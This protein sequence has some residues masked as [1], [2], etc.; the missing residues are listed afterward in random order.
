M[1]TS[2]CLNVMSKINSPLSQLFYPEFSSFL[3]LQ[4]GLLSSPH[5]SFLLPRPPNF[6]KKAFDVNSAYARYRLGIND[7]AKSINKYA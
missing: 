7:Y 4:S 3:E 6:P 1:P 5:L 2:I